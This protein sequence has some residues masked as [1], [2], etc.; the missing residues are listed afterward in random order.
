MVVSAGV[1]IE[2]MMLAE[3]GAIMWS[4]AQLL[5]AKSLVGS[6]NAKAWGFSLPLLPMSELTGLG[7]FTLVAPTVRWSSY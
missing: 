2:C 3:G 4:G 7:S 5:S 6:T 1:H